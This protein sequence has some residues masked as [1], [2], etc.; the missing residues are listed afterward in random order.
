VLQQRLYVIGQG[1]DDTVYSNV[2]FTASSPA[3]VGEIV[4]YGS[5]LHLMARKIFP[6]DG[7]GAPSVETT[8]FPL[9]K[10][11]SGVASVNTLDGVGTMTA[12]KD[13][14]LRIADF[15]VNFTLAKD[16]TAA[17]MLTTVKDAIDADINSPVVAA[18]AAAAATAAYMETGVV[19]AA[20]AAWTAVTDGAFKVTID[21]GSES[22]LTGLNF[23][24][25]A[26]LPAVAAIIETAL[27]ADTLST[28]TVTYSATT[29]KFTI[30]S[31]TLSS[32]SSVTALTAG[33]AGTDISGP[34]FMNGLA[35]V[36]KVVPG[37][38]ADNALELTSKWSGL[39]S[40]ELSDIEVIGDLSGITFITASTTSGAGDPAIQPAVDAMGSSIWYTMVANQINDTTSLSSLSDASEAKWD[41]LVTMP[42]MAVVGGSDRSAAEAISD[43]RKSDRTNCI[44]V[45]DGCPALSFEIGARAV[46]EMV[47]RANSEPN[48]HYTGLKLTGLTAGADT[49]QPSNTAKD[50][51]LKAG[52]STTVVK[53]NVIELED[54]VTFYHPDNEQPDPG[55]RWAVDEVKLWNVMNSVKVA[56]GSPDWQGMT[57]LSDED[58][59]TKPTVRRPKDVKGK[60]FSLTDSW[61][62]EA[63]VTDATFTK[64][65][66]VVVKATG[67]RNR[68]ES[69]IP[70]KLTDSLRQQDLRVD[71]GFQTD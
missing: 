30:T 52:T 27:Q 17:E 51:S 25:A 12:S 63:W 55:Y 38:D 2:K 4:G 67:V 54:V 14:T 56:F 34:D 10:P 24:G 9:A 3:E 44:V 58:I 68:F 23:T 40:E 46:A 15:R 5:P 48:R 6:A 70:V 71:F 13:Y 31:A 18:I 53:S 20:L 59:S 42:F 28:E 32:S 43:A 36:A 57:I 37:T 33:S 64:T 66:M 19:T 11:P 7:S 22:D 8:F 61:V 41:P 60:L 39:T 65:N 50:T 1:R 47:A 45:A 16:S 62:N 29:G 69:I 26:D 35:G 49:D 21:G